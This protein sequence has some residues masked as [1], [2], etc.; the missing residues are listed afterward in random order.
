MR[1]RPFPA[2][3]WKA[4]ICN[5]AVALPHHHPHLGSHPHH[6]AGGN[7]GR[8]IPGQRHR[9]HGRRARGRERVSD[10]RSCIRPG[11]GE[12]R[13]PR[14]ADT[15]ARAD[16]RLC[17]APEPGR[18][19]RF[20]NQPRHRGPHVRDHRGRSRPTDA[21]QVRALETSTRGDRRAVRRS[22]PPPENPRL[23]GLRGHP[24]R[25][26]QGRRFGGAHDP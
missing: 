14:R 25:H 19:P 26:D 5:E 9:L 16:A 6:P 22:R 13:I 20:R 8:R 1:C 23:H 18:D 10:G 3:S 15:D 17:P 11:R 7:P 21:T 12:P 4:R 2:H 24:Q